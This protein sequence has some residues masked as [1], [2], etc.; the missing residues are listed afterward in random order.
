[1][2]DAARTLEYFQQMRL[3]TLNLH[4]RQEPQWRKNLETLAHF[5]EQQS[6]DVIALQE[7]AQ[8]LD[9][10][11]LSEENDVVILQQSLGFLGLTYEVHWTL[12]HIGFE[13]WYEGLGLLSRLPFEIVQEIQIS[14]TSDVTDWQTRRAQLATLNTHNGAFRLCN[15]H[16]GIEGT[17][18]KEL[19]RL[20]KEV[21]LSTMI[22]VGDFNVPN[23]SGDYEVIC[24]L[25]RK[26]DVYLDLVERSDPTFFSGADGWGEQTGER[27]DYV[28]GTGATSITR[29]FTGAQFPRISDHMGLLVDFEF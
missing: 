6:V 26:P 24:E 15:L 11:L 12:N 28:F 13:T 27:I 8:P 7:C 22:V 3:L 19:Q 20:C 23:S 14:E 1:M 21:D 16:L 4:C 25:L 9:A 17:A 29:V 10:S 18:T 2:A 5:I